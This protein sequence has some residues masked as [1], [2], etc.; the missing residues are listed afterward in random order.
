MREQSPNGCD[1]DVVEGR[2]RKSDDD[3][4]QRLAA[5]IQERADSAID[6]A[7]V[8]EKRYAVV[9]AIITRKDPGQ[10][11]LNLPLFSRISLARN[12]R[13]LHRLM[14]VPVSFGFV[15]HA[16]L[17]EPPKEKTKDPGAAS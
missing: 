8:T 14:G 3:A 7:P 16:A 12:I 15:K 5:L 4:P 9:F 10:K 17:L 13:A 2:P 11:S 1:D 6:V